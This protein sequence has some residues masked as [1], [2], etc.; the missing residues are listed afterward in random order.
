MCFVYGAKKETLMRHRCRHGLAILEG[1]LEDHG[2]SRDKVGKA[3]LT[4]DIL[5]GWQVFPEVEERVETGLGYGEIDRR[6]LQWVSH[7]QF[8]ITKPQFTLWLTN[9]QNILCKFLTAPRLVSLT[10]SLMEI[11]LTFVA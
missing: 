1:D 2:L 4:H 8:L 3:C 9:I 6:F 5:D 7:I 11:L 10:L